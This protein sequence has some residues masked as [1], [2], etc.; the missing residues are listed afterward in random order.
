MLVNNI[1]SLSDSG[2]GGSYNNGQ[3]VTLTAVPATNWVFVNWSGALSGSVNPTTI[4][5]DG[6]KVVTATFSSTCSSITGADFTFAPAAPKVGQ[7]VSFTTVITGGTAPITYTWNFGPFGTSTAPTPTSSS[8]RL[9]SETVL[10]YPSAGIR[11]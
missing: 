5:I 1:W 10:P 9:G 7:P 3:V 2:S 4:T 8:L 11:R 6:S